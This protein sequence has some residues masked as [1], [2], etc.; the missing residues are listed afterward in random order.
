MYKNYWFYFLTFIIAAFFL[1]S[2]S[3]AKKAQSRREALIAVDSQLAQS[4]NYL[5]QLDV[6][7]KNKQSKNE[8][9]DTASS[10]IQKYISKTKGEIDTAIQE[11]TLLIGKTLVAR[12]DWNKLKEALLKSQKS[13][14]NIK[15]K[16]SFIN[17]LLKRNTVVKLDQDVIFKPGEYE[18][19][20]AV[21]AAIGKFFEPAAL[22]VDSF[23]NKYPD[24]NLSLVIT[25]KGYADATTIATDSKLYKE[26]KD[27]LK[28]QTETPTAKD[29]ND[30]LSRLR[31]KKVIELFQDFTT[32]RSGK[33]KL[34]NE[35]ILYLFEGKGE[36]FPDPSVTNYKTDDPRRR[37][38]LLFWSIFPE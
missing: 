29:L 19:S 12:E 36:T 37:V 4:K 17:D 11:N 28:L 9:D 13:L 35:H 38:V 8:I 31:A 6:Q 33:R 18:V 20:P 22:G 7:R 1:L 25:A 23:I 14:K 3:S 32:T 34:S 16:T 10:R 27:Q 24:F 26:L 5:S 2:C 15:D 21:A 30:Q